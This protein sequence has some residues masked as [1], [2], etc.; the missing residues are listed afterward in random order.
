VRRDRPTIPVGCWSCELLGAAHLT[1]RSVAES[2][3]VSVWVPPGSCGPGD[4]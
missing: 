1:S 3:H 4:G 2:S